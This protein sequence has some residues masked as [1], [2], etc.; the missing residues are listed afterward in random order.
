[1]TKG[2]RIGVVYLV[3]SN[4]KVVYF[5]G[6]GIYEGEE[7]PSEDAMGLCPAMREAGQKNP[8]LT[9]DNGDVV[10]GGECWWDKESAMITDIDIYRERGYAIQDI[11]IKPM[12]EWQ[13]MVLAEEKKHESSNSPAG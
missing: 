5:L 1:M 6:Y 11:S 7:V 8:K 2:D 3:D 4:A 10:W 13:A 12:R 9:L